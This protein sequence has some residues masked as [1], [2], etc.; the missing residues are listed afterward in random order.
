M[1]VWLRCKDP[2]VPVIV[3]GLEPVPVCLLVLIVRVE[4]STLGTE[5]GLGLKLALE[6]EGNP[7]TLS[8]TEPKNPPEGVMVTVYLA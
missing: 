4:V 6:R 5:I 1:T 8:E 3:N 7:E 2:L